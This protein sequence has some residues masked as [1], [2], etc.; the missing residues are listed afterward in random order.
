MAKRP[1]LSK[2]EME[3][4]RT[5]WNLGEAP[6]GQIYET[7]SEERDIDYSTVQTYIR[8]L[9]A[10]GYIKTRR[11]GR[12]KL[13]SAKVRPGV[14]IGQALDEM[15]NQLFDGEVIP[16]VKHLINDR[17]ITEAEL[18]QLRKLIDQAERDDADD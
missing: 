9:E 16:M 4:A 3:V 1:N 14:V 10:K 8:R 5:I 18:R 13:Y 17:G 11:I 6:L 7:I 2:G 15:M 12:N